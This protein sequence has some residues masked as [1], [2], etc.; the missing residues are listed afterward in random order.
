MGRRESVAAHPFFSSGSKQ[1]PGAAPGPRLPSPVSEFTCPQAYTSPAFKRLSLSSQFL[2]SNLDGG[3]VG[4]V[5]SPHCEYPWAFSIR[6]QLISLSGHPRSVPPEDSVAC[7]CF[8]H[9][10]TSDLTTSYPWAVGR[11]FPTKPRP[12]PQGLPGRNRRRTG[13]G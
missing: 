10:S 5:A 2:F 8:I 4:I 13:F 6:H 1:A 12:G 9:V 7:W 11:V 3:I